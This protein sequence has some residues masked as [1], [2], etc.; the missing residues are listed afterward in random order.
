M[1]NFWTI[2]GPQRIFFRVK[3]F[4]DEITPKERKK[5]LG[6]RLMAIQGAGGEFYLASDSLFFLF[7]FSLAFWC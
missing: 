2:L 5:E 4:D 6:V 1:K 3:S 7:F